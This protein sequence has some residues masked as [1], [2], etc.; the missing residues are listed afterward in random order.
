MPCVLRAQAP[1]VRYLMEDAGRHGGSRHSWCEPDRCRPV[2][3][4]TT[5]RLLRTIEETHWIYVQRLRAV[6]GARQA[7]LWPPRPMLTTQGWEACRVHRQEGAKGG[8]IPRGA[9]RRNLARLQGADDRVGRMRYGEVRVV[10]EQDG[11][12]ID[13]VD[14][15][16][17]AYAS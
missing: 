13:G 15:I 3:T 7:V 14:K 8:H 1:G 16:R 6:Q 9:V 12:M 4:G 2:S 11:I 10:T 17:N 5:N